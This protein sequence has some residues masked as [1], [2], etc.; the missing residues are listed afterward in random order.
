[1]VMK[2]KKKEQEPEEEE[3]EEE[4]GE[5]QEVLRIPYFPTTAEIKQRIFEIHTMV[6][7]MHEHQLRKLKKK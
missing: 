7:Q 2:K 5:E 4:E 6:S 3:E 1:M